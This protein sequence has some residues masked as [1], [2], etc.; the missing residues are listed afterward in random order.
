MILA[1]GRTS[2][3]LVYYCKVITIYSTVRVHTLEG[4]TRIRYGDD[5]VHAFLSLPVFPDVCYFSQ[6]NP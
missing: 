2:L 5:T 1:R 3:Y 4:V 6:Q